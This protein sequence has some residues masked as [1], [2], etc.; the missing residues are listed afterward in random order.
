[1]N[2]IAIWMGVNAH[3]IV[4]AAGAVFAFI[5]LLLFRKRLQFSIVA[6]F[7]LAVLHVVIGMM[8]VSIFAALENPNSYRL[9]MVSIFGGVFFMPIAY[10]AG[11][12][13]TKRDVKS[14]FDIFI[15]CLLFTLMCSRFNCLSSGCCIGKVIPG[16]DGVR[17]PT[18]ETEI[19]FYV[20]LMIIFSPKVLKGKSNG[21]LYPIYMISYGIFR[22]V[23]ETLRE[24]SGTKIF[25]VSHLWALLC[26][27]IGLSIFIEQQ[28]TK[29]KKRK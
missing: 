22:F 4:L 5:W 19:I 20:V 25:H 12:K 11:A 15:I 28:R 8:S 17:W 26:L 10:W 13:L 16:L 23:N 27:C 24:S 9:G 3:I 1:M 6:A 18:R 7:I 2:P 29:K 14:V 21:E